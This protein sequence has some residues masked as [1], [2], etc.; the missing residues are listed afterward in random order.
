MLIQHIAHLKITKYVYPFHHTID[1]VMHNQ[2]KMSP[3]HRAAI[4]GSLE[5]LKSIISTDPNLV[6]SRD[7]HFGRTPLM[8]CILADRFQ[9]ANFLLK[10][11]NLDIN[12]ADKAGRTVLHVAAH[13]SNLDM[14]K[15]LDSVDIDLKPYLQ[16]QTLTASWC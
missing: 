5:H 1:P 13:K 6:N 4:S 11:E 14:L 7:D 12:L 2:N 8:Y 10:F 9:S 3:I 16:D 15:L